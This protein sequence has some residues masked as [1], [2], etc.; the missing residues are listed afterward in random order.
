VLSGVTRANDSRIAD[1]PADHV[2]GSAEE[3]MER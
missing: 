3:L 2:I 1:G